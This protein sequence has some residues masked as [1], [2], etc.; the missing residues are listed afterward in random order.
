MLR[1]SVMISTKWSERSVC[2]PRCGSRLLFWKTPRK[3]NCMCSVELY[4]V[5]AVLK[6]VIL[7]GFCKDSA[8]RTSSSRSPQNRF[9]RGVLHR[10]D[11]QRPYTPRILPNSQENA[12]FCST[13]LLSRPS[14][15]RLNYVRH[16]KSCKRLIPVCLL[17]ESGHRQF[18]LTSFFLK[19][20]TF[21]QNTDRRCRPQ[22]GNPLPIASILT[23]ELNHDRR[24]HQWSIPCVFSH[25]TKVCQAHTDAVKVFSFPF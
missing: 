15:R 12:R 22:M 4:I 21:C 9:R 19:R 24:I 25:R 5:S 10:F 11:R 1:I 13:L 18:A 3:V 23:A 8:S 2:S 7:V 14:S 20:T 6:L 17:F 16:W